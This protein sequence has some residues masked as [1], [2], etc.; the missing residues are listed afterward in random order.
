M[1]GYMS[2]RLT[3]AFFGGVTVLDLEV[4]LQFQPPIVLLSPLMVMNV[5]KRSRHTVDV[6]HSDARIV[7]LWLSYM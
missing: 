3:L 1:R 5:L 7:V 2:G 6:T 4:I